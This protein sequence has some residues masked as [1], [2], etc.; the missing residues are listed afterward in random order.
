DG[1]AGDSWEIRLFATLM[2][3][4][5]CRRLDPGNEVEFNFLFRKFGI[6][7][8]DGNGIKNRV[9]REGYT[10]TDFHIFVG[11]FLESLK[12]LERIHRK[13]QG[14]Q[15]TSQALEEFICVSQEPCK[16]SLARYL[17]TPSEVVDRILDRS[18]VSSGVTSP[19][20]EEGE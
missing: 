20:A 3:A 12:R 13:I 17:F 5:Q 9:L 14:P 2:L 1:S 11:Q 16:L 10:S 7:S 8:P 18:N 19:L 15:T 4:N 6:L